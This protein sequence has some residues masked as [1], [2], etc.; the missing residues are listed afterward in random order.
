[1]GDITM[2]MGDITMDMGDITMDMGDIT[3]DMGDITM[4]MGDIYHGY[5]GH[6][7]RKNVPIPSITNYL[8]AQ[9]RP[10]IPSYNLY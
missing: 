7:F 10:Y 9:G 5:G 1:M 3:M 4:D 2:D 8:H 6:F